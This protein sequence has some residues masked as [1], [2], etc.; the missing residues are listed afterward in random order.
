MKKLLILINLGLVLISCSNGTKNEK[1]LTPLQKYENAV[2]EAVNEKGYNNWRILNDS[3][4]EIRHEKYK[5]ELDE[6][7]KRSSLLKRKQ[8]ISDTLAYMQQ[9]TRQKHFEATGKYILG[10]TSEAS[11]ALHLKMV[12]MM[13]K[14]EAIEYEIWRKY[15]P[16]VPFHLWAGFNPVN[17]LVSNTWVYPKK[18]IP[19]GEIKFHPDGSFEHITDLGYPIL[20]TYPI[21][22]S[23][24][25][26]RHPLYGG[27]QRETWGNWEVDLEGNITLTY[28]IEDAEDWGWVYEKVDRVFEK[29][30]TPGED[31][32]VH[33]LSF[34][35]KRHK[36]GHRGKNQY[37]LS[38]GDP[39][40]QGQEKLDVQEVTNNSRRNRFKFYWAN[41]SEATRMMN[42]YGSYLDAFFKNDLGFFAVTEEE[43]PYFPDWSGMVSNHFENLGKTIILFNRDAKDYFTGPFMENSTGKRY[44]FGVRVNKSGEIIDV[45]V[46]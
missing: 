41:R 7:P 39:A 37:K 16:K 43:N 26:T 11:K 15:Y 38:S 31:Y 45:T 20:A 21:P 46:Q 30:Y 36:D 42:I 40:F 24:E 18:E 35:N 44:A 8:R 17:A 27:F 32:F 22:G 34:E 29:K 23:E 6:N 14:I 9:K 28:S 4:L 13:D 2:S 3:L 12:D 10:N 1:N 19:T 25:R 33:D 5:K